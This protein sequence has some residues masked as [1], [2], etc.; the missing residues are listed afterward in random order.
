M[1]QKP[2]LKYEVKLEFPE[3]G[4]KGFKMEILSWEG[5]PC[6]QK[7]FFCISWPGYIT[8]GDAKQANYMYTKYQ[9]S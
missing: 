8:L 2:K 5:L 1:S 4:V 6:Q 9:R 3:A 7:F